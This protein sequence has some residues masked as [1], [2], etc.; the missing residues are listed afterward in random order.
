MPEQ[1]NKLFER[2]FSSNRN[3]HA[4]FELVMVPEADLE[5]NGFIR[6]KD[7]NTEYLKNNGITKDIYCY[8]K[9]HFGL[10][11]M[12][13]KGRHN[14]NKL[15]EVFNINDVKEIIDL[16]DQYLKYMEETIIND[17]ASNPYDL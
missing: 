10:F 9:Q 1:F 15:E 7:F 17:I 6:L 11:A 16:Y 8:A 4:E 12:P 3:Y 5:E 14:I 13:Y 2:I